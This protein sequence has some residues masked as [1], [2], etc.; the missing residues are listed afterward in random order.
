MANIED[1]KQLT[2]DELHEI[3]KKG[4]DRGFI[5]LCV[6]EEDRRLNILL[7]ERLKKEAEMAEK[8]RM[9]VG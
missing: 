8:L 9:K 3:I 7:Q 4:E 5:K 2:R 1:V 6:E